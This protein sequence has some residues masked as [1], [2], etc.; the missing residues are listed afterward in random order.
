MVYRID[1]Q[2]FTYHAPAGGYASS[3]TRPT[4][5]VSLGFPR[6]CAM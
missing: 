5:A 4:S 2:Y 1:C 3:P 6:L